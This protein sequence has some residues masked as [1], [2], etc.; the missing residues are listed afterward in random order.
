MEVP[1]S[2]IHPTGSDMEVVQKL[3]YFGMKLPEL[4]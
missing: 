2:Y 4:E 1:N 3:V